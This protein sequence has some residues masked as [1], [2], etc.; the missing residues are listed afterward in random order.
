M[1]LLKLCLLFVTVVASFTKSHY[2]WPLWH[3]ILI[4]T[5]IASVTNCE[6]DMKHVTSSLMWLLWHEPTFVIQINA[7][8][9]VFLIVTGMWQCQRCQYFP[10]SSRTWRFDTKP[11]P[12]V[13][14]IRKNKMGALSI[15]QIAVLFTFISKQILNHRQFRSPPTTDKPIQRLPA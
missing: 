1:S 10:V 3:T 12:R 7:V 13:E 9:Q 5:S 14:E 11:R 15:V 8:W 6:F 4:V 2:M